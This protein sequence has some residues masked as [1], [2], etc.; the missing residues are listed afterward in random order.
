MVVNVG[1]DEWQWMNNYVGRCCDVW[2]SFSSPT[3][4]EKK[5]EE[6]EKKDPHSLEFQ[7]TPPH[8]DMFNRSAAE[9]EK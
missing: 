5:K 7:H 6:E 9:E 2:L 8:T 4:K 1:A 3:K